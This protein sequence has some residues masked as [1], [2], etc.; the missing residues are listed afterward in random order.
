MSLGT[1][2]AIKRAVSAGIGVA[3]VSH[4]A[5]GLELKARMLSVVAVTG[6]SIRRPLYRI[7]RRGTGDN[8]AAQAFL[9]L[10]NSG[11]D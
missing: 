1:T 10:V 3:I 9:K 11:Q 8:K 7:W 4:L 6:M 5:I 2:E